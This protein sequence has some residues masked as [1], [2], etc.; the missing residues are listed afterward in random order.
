MTLLRQHG[1][2]FGALCLLLFSAKDGHGNPLK[3]PLDYIEFSTGSADGGPRVPVIAFHGLGDSPKNFSRG[4][5]ASK[6][7]VHWIIPRAP[8]GYGHGYS[9]FELP[10]NFRRQREAMAPGL[11][12]ATQT[13]ARFIGHLKERGKL[14]GKPII[15]G[16]SQGG[17]LSYT[18]AS[19]YDNLLRGAI[20]IAGFLPSTLYPNKP[21]TIPI[22]ALHGQADRVVPYHLA[23]ATESAF[24]KAATRF[25]L[26]SFEAVGH[27]ITVE[28][29]QLI[30][31]S[32]LNM[33]SP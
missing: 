15:L 18:L 26:H 19:K 3:S 4:F 12:S 16:F 27:R 9:W 17:M 14:H 23:K 2:F 21:V 20:P 10:P 33:L 6:L 8:R 31:E 32:V 28:M 1:L 24:L 5:R 25:Q 7:P 29:W 22:I 13:I 30:E 11:S